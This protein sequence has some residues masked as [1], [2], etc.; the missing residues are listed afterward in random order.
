MSVSTRTG[1]YDLMNNVETDVYPVIAPQGLTDPYAVYS[2]RF[3]YIRTQDGIAIKDGYLTVDIYADKYAD[4]GSLA[5]TVRDNLDNQNG[6]Y[7]S[8]VMFV[9]YITSE[10]DGY[11]P[12]LDKFV[13]TQEYV[14]RFEV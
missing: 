12:E 8:E 1:I 7:N 6:T 2:V 9:A 4:C 10:V 11:I 3:E 13:I 14:L 5:D